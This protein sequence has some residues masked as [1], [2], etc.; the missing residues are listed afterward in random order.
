[1]EGVKTICAVVLPIVSVLSLPLL[2]FWVRY[3]IRAAGKG[4]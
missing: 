1:M 4:E 3:R 2:L